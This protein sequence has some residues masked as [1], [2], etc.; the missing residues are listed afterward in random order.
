MTALVTKESQC[1]AFPKEEVNHTAAALKDM[2]DGHLWERLRGSR[3]VEPRAFLMEKLEFL[4]SSWV[5]A[6]ITTQPA[7]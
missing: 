1:P 6:A 4:S 5:P 2:P 3:W 7:R